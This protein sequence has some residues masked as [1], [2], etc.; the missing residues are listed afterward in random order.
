M[1]SLT[2][3]TELRM[4]GGGGS[5]LSKP[6]PS[7]RRC[8]SSSCSSS[9]H[10][11]P[12][13]GN[14]AGVATVGAGAGFSGP[15]CHVSDKAVREMVAGWRSVVGVAGPGIGMHTVLLDQAVRLTDAGGYLACL[16]Q[17]QK[18]Q[19]HSLARLPVLHYHVR[20]E[21]LQTRQGLATAAFVGMNGC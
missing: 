18:N 9:G 10:M 15:V 21:S 19:K 8:P 14:A 3:L 20:T 12:G 7:S 11:V 16:S 2:A 17:K 1:S 5:N 13:P 6:S 4:A